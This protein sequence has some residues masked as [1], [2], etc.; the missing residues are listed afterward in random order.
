VTLRKG[1]K[2][3]FIIL[4]CTT[5]PSIVM[6]AFGYSTA[7]IYGVLFGSVISW[8]LASVLRETRSW[9]TV[10]QVG[11]FIAIMAVLGVHL[12]FPNIT[13]YWLEIFKK[14]YIDAENAFA[15]KV[16]AEQLKTII[17]WMAKMATGVQAVALLFM[18]I[19]NVLIA[20][21]WQSLLYNPGGLANELLNLR[22]KYAAVLATLA[23]CG[24]AMAGFDIA[25]DLL[26]IVLGLFFIVGLSVI[27][28]LALMSKAMWFILIGYY[29][30]LIFLF[31]Y[32]GVLTVVMGVLDTFIDFR[33]RMLSLR[34]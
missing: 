32:M 24:F 16:T 14:T 17:Q 11:G 22:L 1:S 28:S 27:H 13:A 29:I 6:A 4:L 31:P 25:W 33:Q 3:G 34:A 9:S 26:P 20:R 10:I 19:F 30:F 5:I 23:I 7:I 15:L 21:W 2:E 8:I 12:F 18:A